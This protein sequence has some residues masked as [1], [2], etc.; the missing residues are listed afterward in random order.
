MII[1]K[2]YRKI[3]YRREGNWVRFAGGNALKRA[4]QHPVPLIQRAI[5]GHRADLGNVAEKLI[6]NT[7]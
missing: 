2:D 7:R 6:K 1:G 5:D 4:S 3:T